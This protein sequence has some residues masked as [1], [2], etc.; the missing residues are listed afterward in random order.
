MRAKKEG[1]DGGLDYDTLSLFFFFLMSAYLLR[2]VATDLVP[3]LGRGSNPET[4][5]GEAQALKQ[6]ADLVTNYGSAL[7]I[8]IL[9]SVVAIIVSLP[10]FARES[11][12]LS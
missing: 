4:W 10:L 2:K 3:K 5:S 8:G 1:D 11:A 6:V 7:V 12:L 9:V